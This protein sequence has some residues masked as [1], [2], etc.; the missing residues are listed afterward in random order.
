MRIVLVTLFAVLSI[1]IAVMS[2]EKIYRPVDIGQHIDNNKILEERLSNVEDVFTLDKDDRKKISPK[3]YQELLKQREQ[4]ME[5]NKEE[6]LSRFASNPAFHFEEEA[7]I[8]FVVKEFSRSKVHVFIVFTIGHSRWHNYQIL[9]KNYL[10]NRNETVDQIFKLKKLDEIYTAE[11]HGLSHGSSFPEILKSLGVNYNEYIGQTPQYQN[12][13]FSNHDLEVIIQDGYIKYLQKGKPDWV[14]QLPHDNADNNMDSIFSYEN[15]DIRYIPELGFAAIDSTGAFLFEVF[16]YDNGPDYPS[17]GLIRIQ[18]NG[19]VGYANLDGKIVIPPSFECAYPFK[20]GVAII[21]EGGTLIRKGE[22]NIWK[23]AR[24]GAIDKAGTIIVEPFELGIFTMDILELSIYLH[25]HFPGKFEVKTRLAKPDQ[26]SFFVSGEEGGLFVDLTSTTT[27]KQLLV[28]LFLPWQDLYMKPTSVNDIMIPTEQLV[29]VTKR[30]IVYHVLT[31]P[32]L[33]EVE[34]DDIIH[35]S[36]MMRKLL[37]YEET[38]Q[39]IREEDGIS[40]TGGMQIISLKEYPHYLEVSVATPGTGFLHLDEVRMEFPQKMTLLHQ[41][42]DMG[43]IRSNWIKP[44]TQQDY[45]QTTDTTLEHT[46]ENKPDAIPKILRNSDEEFTDYQPKQTKDNMLDYMPSLVDNL[47]EIP[48]ANLNNL[49]ELLKVYFDLRNRAQKNPGEWI[50]G[51]IVLGG[52][53]REYKPSPDELILNEIGDRIILVTS[54]TDPEI[55][56]DVLK[57]I[58]EYPNMIEYTKYFFIHYD[59]MGSGR[60]FYIDEMEKIEFNLPK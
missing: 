17:D 31:A 42:P 48:I 35:L 3:A 38:Q 12:L 26:I 25:Q 54:E 58:G 8:D 47:D 41:I 53:E 14:E 22:H 30:Y 24:W 20:N 52:R 19:K 36:D 27:G 49:E 15:F 44:D 50:D 33:S 9:L 10:I 57:R 6:Y 39:L 51:N 55:L 13:Y 59:I 56:S 46:K 43:S 34:M 40:S 7:L 28:Y 45:P 29:T 5:D 16:P 32:L 11:Y 4:W 37:G 23:E 1:Q 18:D 2:Q 21:C 60:F